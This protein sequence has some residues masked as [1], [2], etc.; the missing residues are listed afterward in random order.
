MSNL[1]SK[2]G[3]TDKDTS[4]LN[5]VAFANKGLYDKPQIALALR[6]QKL[7]KV[8]YNSNGSVNTQV[9]TEGTALYNNL[10]NN[11]EYYKDSLSKY[12]LV[13]TTSTIAAKPDGYT[14]GSLLYQGEQTY[15]GFAVTD[16][17]VTGFVNRGTDGAIDLKQDV[18]MALYQS[19]PPYVQQSVD[20]MKDVYDQQGSQ[21]SAVDLGIAKD[22]VFTTGFSLGKTGSDSQALYVLESGKNLMGN[23]SFEGYGTTEVLQRA[24]PEAFA[25][26]ESVL[27]SVTTNYVRAND[28]VPENFTS[29][30]FGNVVPITSGYGVVDGFTDLFNGVNLHG[31]KNYR[32]SAYDAEGNIIPDQL[33]TVMT[34]KYLSTLDS[35][36]NTI[37][38]Q[39]HNLSKT[40]YAIEYSEYLAD[41]ANP[42]SFNKDNLFNQL[43]SI[44]TVK[45]NFEKIFGGYNN[46]NGVDNIRYSVDNMV[47]DML[48]GNPANQNIFQVL[49]KS[50]SEQPNAEAKSQFIAS[51]KDNPL[52]KNI[53]DSTFGIQ[54]DDLVD[55]ADNLADINRSSQ[56]AQVFRGDPLTFDLDGDGIETLS[57]EEGVLFDHEAK[58]VREGTG[59][60]SADDGLLVRDIDGN[61]TIDSGRELFGDNTLKADGTKAKDG[62]DALSDLDT[63]ADGVFNSKDDAFDSVQVWQDKD[64]DGVTDAGELTS[65][66]EA[67]ISSIDL[68]AKTVNQSVAG[69]ILRKTST[70]T[71]TDGTTTAVGA[72]DFAVQKTEDRGLKTERR[73]NSPLD[74]RR[75]G[76]EALAKV[77][78]KHNHRQTANDS[79]YNSSL[80]M[81]A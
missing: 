64:Q 51:L 22:N 63:N 26:F 16:G 24:N 35:Q 31:I 61:G 47:I 73:I 39:L 55:I 57:V 14:D 77:L 19:N 25:T 17:I 68:N 11:P 70:A 27:K 42:L 76:S 59:W 80:G 71:N 56:Q 74:S 34:Q 50:I 6:G 43:D 28:A 23:V 44:D 29:T 69:G 15:H 38:Q 40:D 32:F 3:F 72:M 66:V 9:V 49:S 20:F 58:Q 46:Y 18:Q 48:G 12:T 60:I 53:M 33:N 62:F 1:I 4:I 52:I 65:L 5:E 54:S 8:F 13:E 67:G 37:N 78:I 45:E 2:P 36:A 41:K 10:T 79:K 75:G 81:A 30:Q 21:D 7:D